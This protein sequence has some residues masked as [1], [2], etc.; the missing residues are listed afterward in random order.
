MLNM[1]L[2]HVYGMAGVFPT[3]LVSR[4]PLAVVP[5]PRDMDDMLA[6]IK[7]TKPAF[8]PGV[9][10]LFNALLNHPK[11]KAGKVSL[12][13]SKV[14]HLRGSALL[15]RDQDNASRRRREG[16]LSRGLA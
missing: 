11:V 10:T 16:G 5:N 15:D 9:P 13:S 14:E 4:A 6:T 12:K 8:L 3:G 2:F 1:P 7:K